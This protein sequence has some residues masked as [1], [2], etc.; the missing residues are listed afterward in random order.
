MSKHDEIPMVM[1][2]LL[3]NDMFSTSRL[4]VQIAE[5]IGF[6]KGYNKGRADGFKAAQRNMRHAM[7]EAQ[8]AAGVFTDEQSTR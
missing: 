2:Q 4:Q 6:D 5:R 8:E 3:L 7:F 1:V